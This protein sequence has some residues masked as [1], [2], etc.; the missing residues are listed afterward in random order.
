MKTLFNQHYDIIDRILAEELS[1]T[2]LI[3]W[4]RIVQRLSNMGVTTERQ[5]LHKRVKA[6]LG[7]RPGVQKPDPA[8]RRRFW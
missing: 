3:D 4:P 5:V 6:W 8:Q 1:S 7:S 2:G